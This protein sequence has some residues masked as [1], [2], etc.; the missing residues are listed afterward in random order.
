MNLEIRET[1]SSSDSIA[2]LEEVSGYDHSCMDMN[3]A[4]NHVSLEEDPIFRWVD[5]LI[6]GL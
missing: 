5:I 2:G 6:A 3:S 1:Q 4:T